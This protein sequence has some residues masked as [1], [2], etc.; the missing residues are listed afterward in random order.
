MDMA[1]DQTQV[2]KQPA[3]GATYTRL[4]AVG[5]AA[6]VGPQ[7]VQPVV[8]FLAQIAHNLAPSVIPMLTTS[9]EWS[10]ASLLCAA[11]AIWAAYSIRGTTVTKGAV[12]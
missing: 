11:P 1:D 2:V 4:A 12:S 5:A 8:D 10:V 9:A 6:G 3:N 7:V